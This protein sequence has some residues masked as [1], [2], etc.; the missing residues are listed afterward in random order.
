MKN[1]VVFYSYDGSTRVAANVIAVKF[2]AELFELEEVKKRGRSKLSFVA[3]GFAAVSGKKS[4]LKSIYEVELKSVDRIYIGT[5]I[6]ASKPVPAINT[7]L[8]NSDIENKE[9][10]I[11]TLQADPNPGESTAKSIGAMKSMLEQKG[12]KVMSSA[13]L[14]GAGPGKTVSVVDIKKQIDNKL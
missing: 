12:A 1:A 5:P 3:A 6:W 7:F 2:S 13:M 4:K 8:K 10:V 11:F 9:I 14:V